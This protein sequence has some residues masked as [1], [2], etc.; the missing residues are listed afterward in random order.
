MLVA[1]ARVI[2]GFL[3]PA[4]LP[5]G[6]MLVSASVAGHFSIERP[7]YWQFSETPKGQWSGDG[8]D[9]SVV[10]IIQY[11]NF[12]KRGVIILIRRAVGHYIS[13]EEV[14]NWGEQLGRKQQSF[15]EFSTQELV[16]GGDGT[17]IREYTFYTPATPI[18][19]SLMLQCYDNY[20]FRNQTAY[21]LTFC[22][23]AEDFAAIKPTFWRMIES[24]T[25]LD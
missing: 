24:F 10:T 1:F 6:K 23:D 22:V 17:I 14:S 13:I 5:T 2:L 3:F 8:S 7:E 9:S 25:Y 15:R 16:V 20:R 19:S 18:Q 21:V 12:P 11:S 4:S